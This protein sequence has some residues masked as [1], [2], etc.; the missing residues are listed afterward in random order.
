MHSRY[1]PATAITTPIQMFHPAF[2][3]QEQ[4]QDRYQDDIAGGQESGL[5]GR[6]AQ[7]KAHL[8]ERAAGETA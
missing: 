2:L 6:G 1:S 3:F 5:P 7:V 8:L 4:P